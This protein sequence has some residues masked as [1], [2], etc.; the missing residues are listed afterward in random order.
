MKYNNSVKWETIQLNYKDE[1][2]KKAIK[3]EY[4]LGINEGR[5]GKPIIGHNNY[6]EGKSYLLKEVKPQEFVNQYVG[7]GDI[8]R[9]IN[10]DWTN[11][12]FYEHDSDIGYWVDQETGK[13]ILTNRI[14]ISYSKNNGKHVVPAIPKGVD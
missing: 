10:G 5:Q 7:T 13:A 12:Q 2:L 6:V 1:T 8:R 11:K 14:S 9:S 4:N 3:T